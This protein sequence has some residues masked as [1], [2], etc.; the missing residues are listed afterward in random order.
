MVLMT[1][2]ASTRSTEPADAR[3]IDDLATPHKAAIRSME[4]M[5]SEVKPLVER[6]LGYSLLAWLSNPSRET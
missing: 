3:L 4:L 5:M 1:T 2:P 6:A